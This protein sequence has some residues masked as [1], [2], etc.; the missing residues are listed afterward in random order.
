MPRWRGNGK[1]IFYVGPEAKLMSAAVIIKGDSLE[2]G[3]G[4]GP[5][6]K[7]CIDHQIPS[8]W[9]RTDERLPT[10]EKVVIAINL[11]YRF[12]TRSSSPAFTLPLLID[13]AKL[14][15]WQVGDEVN[16]AVSGAG[17]TGSGS[18]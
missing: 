15:W 10:V 16:P 2:V 7:S 6:V 4:T 8:K 14:R 9:V 13:V 5:T 1:E 11:K 17:K 12:R 18:I 3:V